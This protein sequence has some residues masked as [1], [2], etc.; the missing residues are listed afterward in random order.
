MTLRAHML[1]PPED[2]EWKLFQGLLHQDVSV[3]KGPITPENADFEILIAGYPKTKDLSSSPH[4]H[5][6]LIPW[7]GLPEPTQKVLEDFP[8]LAVHNIHHNAQAVA[9]TAL[10][11]LMATAKCSL[12]FDRALRKG[13]WTSR[14]QNR[15]QAV[16]LSGKTALILGYGAIGKRLAGL[17]QAFDMKVLAMKRS[18]PPIAQGA[19]FSPA[20]TRVNRALISTSS[21]ASLP[22][23]EVGG[24]VPTGQARPTSFTATTQFAFSA[25][26][27]VASPKLYG[28]DALHALLPEVDV[29]LI[30]LPLTKETRGMIGKKELDL[31]PER[32][33]V[34]NVA[35][36]EIV[37]EEALFLALQEGKL[38]GAGLDVWYRYPSSLESRE[39]TYPSS[40]PFHELDNVVMSPHRADSCFENEAIRM[41]FLADMLNFVAYGKT[42]PNRMRR[43]LGY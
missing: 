19:S 5:T 34:V 11:L 41:R 23:L 30:C 13:D 3:T 22:S 4:L 42:M 26:T 2:M 20:G 40:F 33:I 27:G 14:Y 15:N 24:Q 8:E 31:L 10:T 25:S 28:P 37:D 32:A 43:D 9:E 7:S 16:L 18:A 36:G 17:C 12:P 38:H 21:S 39:K 1:L 6:L 29:L 35:R